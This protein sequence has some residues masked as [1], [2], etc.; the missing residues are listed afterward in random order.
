MN[1]WRRS[2]LKFHKESEIYWMFNHLG[3]RHAGFT[4]C[5]WNE[6]M[7]H[8]ICCFLWTQC[9]HTVRLKELTQRFM[10]KIAIGWLDW[11]HWN[12]Q[13]T[14]TWTDRMDMSLMLNWDKTELKEL[15][16]SH[17]EVRHNWQ[18][19]IF[20]LCW[21]KR[22]WTDVVTHPEPELHIGSEQRRQTVQSCC[23]LW[24]RLTWKDPAQQ[25][26]DKKLNEREGI[27]QSRWRKLKTAEAAIWHGFGAGIAHRQQETILQLFDCSCWQALIVTRM[28][29]E[30]IEEQIPTGTEDP[31]QCDLRLIHLSNW[32]LIW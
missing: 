11:R 25:N 9:T 5:L 30:G 16:G 27:S 10:Q 29:R 26:A 8:T 1:D 31:Y 17:T 32:S 18:S 19:F 22:H 14:G 15:N 7:F 13:F 21:F 24:I 12:H 20:G 3:Y 23:Y 6:R 2:A 4:G 28:M